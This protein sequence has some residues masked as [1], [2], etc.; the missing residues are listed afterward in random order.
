M[1]ETDANLPTSAA[2]QTGINITDTAF[3]TTSR[4]TT[5]VSAKIEKFVVLMQAVFYGLISSVETRRIF[6]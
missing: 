6:N 4:D 2:V 3:F 5:K 1:N